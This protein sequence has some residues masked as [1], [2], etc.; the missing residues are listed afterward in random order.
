MTL[1]VT[2]DVPEVVVTPEAS[3]PGPAAPPSV[4]VVDQGGTSVAVNGAGP[5]V[6]VSG[7]APAVAVAVS[8]SRVTVLE[9]AAGLQGPPGPV[10]PQGQT[11]QPGP[12]GGSGGFLSMT[13]G[14]AAAH[15]R[16]QA[17]YV[18]GNDVVKLA[19]AGDPAR[20]EVV[21]LVA[22]ATVPGSAAGN[23]QAG[24]VLGGLSGLTPN[25]LYF[26]DPATPGALT[27]AAPSA[28]GQV[29][30]EVGVGVSLTEILVRPRPVAVL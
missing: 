5:Q 3:P 20:S 13:N 14:D 27:A 8:V 10:G 1:V 30:V 21:A 16:G 28:V 4:V 22:D 25:T 24:G 23:Y 17:V 26:L 19:V 18:S 12:P 2:A 6:S 9:A 15:S 29:V 7:A 11:G